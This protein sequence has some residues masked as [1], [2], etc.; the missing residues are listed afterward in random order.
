[1]SAN[2]SYQ[3]TAEDVE[4]FTGMRVSAKTQQRLVQRQPFDAPQV[5]EPVGEASLDG[6]MVRLIVEPGQPPS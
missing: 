6:G 4:L 1:V 3:H 2:A 5:S